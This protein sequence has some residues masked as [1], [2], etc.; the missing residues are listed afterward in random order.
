MKRDSTDATKI[1]L[2][3]GLH[4]SDFLFHETPPKATKILGSS[5]CFF[6]AKDSSVYCLTHQKHCKR[7]MSCDDETTG[8]SFE[9][10]PCVLF[11]LCLG[12]TV[13]MV[14]NCRFVMFFP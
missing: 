14:I 8:A 10:P 2:V 9:G 13:A 7:K 12:K 5:R 1:K 6:F 4:S 3:P 11:S